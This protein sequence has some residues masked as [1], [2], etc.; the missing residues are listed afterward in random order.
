MLD[1]EP[2]KRFLAEFQTWVLNDFARAD[3]S[4]EAYDLAP[5]E[6]ADL[7][8]PWIE[9]AAHVLGKELRQLHAEDARVL[10]GLLNHA[11]DRIERHCDRRGQ[12]FA[13]VLLDLYPLEDIL[14]ALAFVE[15]GLTGAD[16]LTILA[17]AESAN[18]QP[19]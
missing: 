7:L 18:H 5:D 12:R 11:L 6:L 3:R 1:S 13:D 10:R 16:L 2:A 19:Q 4:I 15:H 17:L 14:I 8:R 9:L